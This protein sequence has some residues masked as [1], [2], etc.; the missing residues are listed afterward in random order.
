MTKIE[1]KKK[2]REVKLREKGESVTMC[3]V[4]EYIVVRPL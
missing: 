3:G 4:R 1:R 2:E